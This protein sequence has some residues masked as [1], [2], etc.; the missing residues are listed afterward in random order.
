MHYSKGVHNYSIITLLEA[1]CRKDRNHVR[2]KYYVIGLDNNKLK[3][4]RDNT[5]VAK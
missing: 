1:L 2:N 5:S 4:Y 3:C